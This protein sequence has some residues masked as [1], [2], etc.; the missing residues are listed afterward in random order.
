MLRLRNIVVL[1]KL[2]SGLRMG[3]MAYAL[4][5]VTRFLKSVYNYF[6]ALPVVWRV[7]SA[8]RKKRARNK[9]RGIIFDNYGLCP[10]TIN[11]IIVFKK[12][13][14]IRFSRYGKKT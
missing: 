6:Q 12:F 4:I 10:Y 14:S 13:F 1:P 7:R 11:K 8:L 2:W 9:L 3:R 5:V